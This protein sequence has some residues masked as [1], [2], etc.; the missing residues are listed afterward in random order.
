MR[1]PRSGNERFPLVILL[2]GSGGVSNYVLDWEQE[3]LAMD[4]ATFVIDSFT[5]RGIVNTNNDR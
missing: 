5:S 1:L 4:V 3:F 2:H